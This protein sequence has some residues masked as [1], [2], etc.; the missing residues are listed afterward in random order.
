MWHKLEVLSAPFGLVGNDY[1]IGRKIMQFRRVKSL[2]AMAFAIG[3]VLAAP[4]MAQ[5]GSL[6]V[7]STLR[8]IFDNLPLYVALEGGLYK[9]H[10]I[11][12]EVTHFKGGGDVVRAVSGGAGDIGMVGTS[13][14][15]V[16]ASRGAPLKIFSAWSAP[17]FGIY[18]IVPVDSPIKTVE[19]IAGKKVGFTRP[20]SVTHTGLMAVQKAKNIQAQGIPVGSAGDGWAMAKVGRVDVTWHSAPDVY[21]LIDR[22]EGR[23]LIDIAEYLKE[24]QQ[25]S[26]VA[27]EAT[28]A[29]RKGDIA[30][31]STAIEEANKM[32]AS[33]PAAAAMHGAKGMKLPAE[34][35]QEMIKTM[36]KDFFKLGPPTAANFAGS[37]EEA[38]ATGGLKTARDYN[39][40]VDKSL[41]AA[42]K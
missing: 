18:F 14:A 38:V 39:S 20:G 10:G 33:S 2:S 8:E 30:K 35:L 29:K 41:F 12:V 6:K 4:A 16:A 19:D 13:A 42:S 23:I 5:T 36:P 1:N 25:G 27:L 17:S 21:S 37:L 28:L 32:I 26:L 31:F 11:D 3:S 24:Y 15:I 7:A 40:M 34:K 9:K 22:K